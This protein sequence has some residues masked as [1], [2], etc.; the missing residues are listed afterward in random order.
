MASNTLDKWHQINIHTLYLKA[1]ALWNF[2]INHTIK[3]NGLMGKWM[4]KESTFGKMETDTKDNIKMGKDGVSV[5]W[6][7]QKLLINLNNFKIK[8]R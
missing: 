5:G 6:N 2:P 1:K 3:A 8:N 4:E 7:G